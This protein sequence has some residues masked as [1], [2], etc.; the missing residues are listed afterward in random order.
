MCEIW[1]PIL[2]NLLIVAR[3]IDRRALQIFNNLWVKWRSKTSTKGDFRLHMAPKFGRRWIR[4][5]FPLN[6][7]S[8]ILMSAQILKHDF[9]LQFGNCLM[10]CRWERKQNKNVDLKTNAFTCFSRKFCQIGHYNSLLRH[11]SRFYLLLSSSFYTSN[12]KKKPFKKQRT[13][14]FLVLCLRNRLLA[15]VGIHD[16]TFRSRKSIKENWVFDS[17]VANP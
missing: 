8:V 3:S 17:V 4:K 11:N 14:H 5:F 1:S 6:L 15:F 7:K 13:S 12:K 16:K 2:D 9:S 10:I